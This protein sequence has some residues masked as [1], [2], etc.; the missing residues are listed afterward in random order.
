[1]G[2]RL[3]RAGRSPQAIVAALAVGGTAAAILLIGQTGHF[4][5]LLRRLR[6]ATP[7]WLIVCAVGEMLA[8]LGFFASYQAMAE[9]SGG[10]RIPVPVVARVVG[11]SFGAFSVATAIGGLSV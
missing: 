2:D 8:Y 3:R 5:E 10:P 11:L 4:G 9:S 6:H 1:M 7:G